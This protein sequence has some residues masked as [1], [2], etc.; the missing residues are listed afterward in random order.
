[1][2]F[3]E[4]QFL[5][6]SSI[7]WGAAW[8]RHQI[9]AAQ[10]AEAGH[11]VF[12]VENTGFRNPSLQDVPRVFSRLGSLTGRRERPTLPPRLRVISPAVLPPTWLLF[13]EANASLLV[14]YLASQLR[15]RG[16]RPGCI[17]VCYFPTPTTLALI[18]EVG[19]SL[20]VYDCAS[21]F[22]GHPHAPPDFARDERRL[23]D[24]SALV[25]TDSDF[26][27]EQKK[28]EHANV[29]Q[30]HQGVPERFFDA[31][32]PS[33]G[34]RKLCYYGTWIDDIDPRYIAALAE[35]GF[36]V[37]ISGFIKASTA[38][39]PSSVKI[40]PPTTPE[41][42]VE[43]LQEFDAFLFPYRVNAFTRG[44]IPAKIYECLAMGRPVLAAPLPSLLPLK[45]F[46]Y[47]GESPDEW[48]R[49]AGALPASETDEKR[50]AR[51]ELARDHTYPREFSRLMAHV[52][53]AWAVRK[54]ASAPHARGSR[55]LE[56]ARGFG[57]IGTLYGAARAMTLAG[58]ML[59]G[60][61]LG[62]VEYGKANLVVA[63]AAFLQVVPTLGLP[64]ALAK[65]PAEEG[66]QD[67]QRRLISSALTVFALWVAASLPA[68]LYWGAPL[69]RLARCP[70]P[71]WPLAVALAF[72][73]AAYTVLA[74]PLL[75]LKRFSSR[76]TAEALYGFCAPAA[77]IGLALAGDR[78]FRG[79]I[80]ALCC[81]L[82]AASLYAAWELR[83]FLRPALDRAALRKVIGYASL[84][85]FSPLLGA[86]VLAPARLI[87]N[88]SHAAR[89]VGVF[90]AY[91]TATAQVSLAA[92]TIVS[93]VLVPLAS[94]AA[95]Q[96]QAWAAFRRLRAP[97]GAGA[98]AAFCATAAGSLAFFGRQYPLRP[99]WVA[100][101]AAAS[102]LILIH[103]V[104]GALYAAKDLGGLRVSITGGAIVSVLNVSL[105]LLLIP[106]FGI[107][108]AAA[109]L[110]GAY[111]AGLA[112]Y[113]W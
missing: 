13:R 68:T 101:F 62:P 7:D 24:A 72:A 37:T 2:T 106:K 73:T 19:P 99:E 66:D 47:I 28:A 39:L 27:F 107:A 44:V 11:D 110:V 48:L 29:A 35:A 20:V 42:L 63:M 61:L 64:A 98:F 54:D 36:D 113:M 93:A 79:L 52:E 16:L 80:L 65:F 46:L 75:G 55:W 50:R 71:L 43:R 86:C 51:I 34:W 21:N 83:D 23:L 9:F 3:S 8:Q 81:G 85:S 82:G 104:A 89:E 74:S 70:S 90:S 94:G 77:L 108:G 102:A 60:R 26:L 109:A 18:E 105:S 38:S 97:L 57:W 95:G 87:L 22:R 92:L 67:A 40:L 32:P 91:F 59:A 56:Y 4:T 41:K 100:A 6:I 31:R 10:M 1:M 112:Y 17:V 15:S 96:Q 76:G 30:V 69:A 58:Q 33:G 12:F 14:P 49:L 53:K 84:A 103:G 25:V 111:A 88:H 5:I 45:N 78:S